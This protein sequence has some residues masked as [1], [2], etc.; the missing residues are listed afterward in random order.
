LNLVFNSLE[1]K[2]TV[3]LGDLYSALEGKGEVLVRE[4]GPSDGRFDVILANPPYIPIPK[5]LKARHA[6]GDGGPDGERIIKRIIQMAPLHLTNTGRVH[7]VSNLMNLSIYERKLWEWWTA[8]LHD[9]WQVDSEG[10]LDKYARA[11]KGEVAAFH[12]IRGDIWSADYY[13][14][15]GGPSGLKVCAKGMILMTAP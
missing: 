12:L 13:G 8:N 6:Y 10:V 5:G 14:K 3:L 1:R 11:P 15:M 7:I 2:G 9:R 4:G